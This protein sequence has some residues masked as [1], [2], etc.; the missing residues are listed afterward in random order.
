LSKGR[1]IQPKLD[2]IDQVKLAASASAIQY[3]SDANNDV[4]LT[5]G[6]YTQTTA[7]AMWSH[8]GTTQSAVA[9]AY[10][11]YTQYQFFSPSAGVAIMS[12]N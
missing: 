11:H 10:S 3:A 1:T 6:K 5:V 12:Y 7:A 9:I 4:Q 8:D 2:P